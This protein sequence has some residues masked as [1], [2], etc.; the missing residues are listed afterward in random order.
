MARWKADA[1]EFTVSVNFH[2]TRG[3]QLNV[4]RPVMECLAKPARITFVI[5]GTRVEVRAAQ[6]ACGRPGAPSLALRNSHK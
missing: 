6:N 1:R 2:R 4:P 3:Y 5:R